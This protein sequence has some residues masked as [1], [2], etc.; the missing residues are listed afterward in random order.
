MSINLR[1]A[2]NAISEVIINRPKPLR[3]FDQIYMR[4]GD[5][6]LQVEH[7]SK[8]F[9]GQNIVFIG[10]GDSIALC[11]IHLNRLNIIEKGPKNIHV[12]DFDER[13][14]LS[15]RHFANKFKIQDRI[16]SELY[17]VASP[18]P[19]KYWQ[20]F[21]GFYTNPP[22]GAS[23][24]GSS[25]MAFMQRGVEA[26]KGKSTASIVIAD[27]PEKTW[28]QQVLFSTQ[29]YMLKS[30]FLVSEL[31]PAFHSYHLDDEPSLKSCALSF[32]RLRFD[33]SKYSSKNLDTK[34]LCE[35]YGVGKPL[36]FRFVR[37]LTE[38]GNIQSKD[39]KLESYE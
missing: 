8:L 13:I 24:K 28:T 23:N 10:D 36:K 18:L 25:V 26:C 21:D 16:T 20:K 9:D 5:M 38:G 1:T 30:D 11:L 27:D 2:L 4:A 39:Y 19:K 15:I 33:K 14:V 29:E 37:D 32:K 17:N 3:E 31:I 12:L 6:L 35:F 7:V 22:Y 34:M